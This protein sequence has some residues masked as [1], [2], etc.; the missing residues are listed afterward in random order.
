[1]SKEIVGGLKRTERELIETMNL[2]E[3]TSW[4][5]KVLLEVKLLISGLIRDY[6]GDI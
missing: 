5:Y 4:R 1:M 2:L 6:E 3:L